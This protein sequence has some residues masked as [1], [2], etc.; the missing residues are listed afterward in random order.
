MH[1]KY[2]P[3]SWRG[4]RAEPG[5][6]GG[7][8]CPQLP[9]PAEA[10]LHLSG[11]CRQRRPNFSHQLHL[12]RLRCSLPTRAPEPGMGIP[13]PAL[14]PLGSGARE[15]EVQSSSQ[16]SSSPSRLRVSSL[17]GSRSPAP[18]G[19]TKLRLSNGEEGGCRYTIPAL[20]RD[21]ERRGLIRTPQFGSALESGEEHSRFA[22]SG[23]Q[24]SGRVSG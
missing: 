16:P 13:G 5:V 9:G 20:S 4:D 22:R 3:G 2:T 14:P 23:H 8:P 1:R 19:Q 12:P 24:S 18:E 6:R 15:P 10:R 11:T 7:G 17:Q 21:R